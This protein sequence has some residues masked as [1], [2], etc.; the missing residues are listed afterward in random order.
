VITPEAFGLL[1]PAACIA[2]LH[3]IHSPGHSR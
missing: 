2:L 1:D 3:S